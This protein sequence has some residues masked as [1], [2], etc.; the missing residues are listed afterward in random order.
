MLYRIKKNKDADYAKAKEAEQKLKDQ[1]RAAD[2][3]R[4]VRGTIVLVYR[5]LKVNT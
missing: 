1:A 5:E 2:E 4:R 3:N